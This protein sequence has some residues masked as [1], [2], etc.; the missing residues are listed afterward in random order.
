MI[1]VRSAN[2]QTVAL[3][4]LGDQASLRIKVART[5]LLQT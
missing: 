2:D 5:A 4:G 1:G 3:S